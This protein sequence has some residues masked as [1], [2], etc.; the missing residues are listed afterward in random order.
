MYCYVMDRFI[1]LYF[2]QIMMLL[3]DWFFYFFYCSYVMNNVFLILCYLN[4]GIQ[5]GFVVLYNNVY[6]IINLNIFIKNIK[7]LFFM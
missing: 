7:N 1:Y 5:N 6:Y 3:I 4:Y 2:G